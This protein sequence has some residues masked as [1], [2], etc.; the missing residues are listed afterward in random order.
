MAGKHAYRKKRP[1]RDR[2]WVYR[3]KS[4]IPR[5]WNKIGVPQVRGTGDE[6]GYRCIVWGLWFTGYVVYAYRRCNCVNCVDVRAAR[7][8]EAE[9]GG[10]FED[11]LDM[12]IRMREVQRKH[13][14]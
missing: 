10:S 3:R 14:Q 8:M 5:W 1:F 7:D 11:W 9:Y 4:W 2:W 6:Y 12:R 13:P